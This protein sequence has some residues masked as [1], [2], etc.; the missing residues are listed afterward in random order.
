MQSHLIS[1]ITS[2]ALMSLAALTMKASADVYQNP[3]IAADIA[4]P[5]VIRVGD[6]FYATGT[7]SEW[8]PHY[9]I[10]TSKDLV[11]WELIGHVFDKTPEWASS[12]FWAPELYHHKGTYHVYYTARRRRTMSR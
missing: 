4:D 1:R 2:I 8:A 10:Y 11:R 12:S 9:P 5:S 7:S 6:T 3:V